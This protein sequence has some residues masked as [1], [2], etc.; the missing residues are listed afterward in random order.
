MPTAA[1]KAD[2]KQFRRRTL[3][4]AGVLLATAA[5][6]W[7]LYRLSNLLFMVFVSVFAGVAIEPAVHYLEKRGW[8]RGRATGVVF[9]AS[10]LLV[11]IF[12]IALVPLFVR[13]ID[14]L[15]DSVPT[16]VTRLA[17][18][19]EDTFGVQL[20]DPQVQ[21]EGQNL[22][23]LLTGAGG[24][25]VGGLLG[26]TAGVANFLI[27][28]TTVAIFTFYIVAELPKL[29]HTILSYMPPDRQREALH[30]WDIAVEKMGGYIYSRLILAVLSSFLATI[31]LMLLGVPF[32]VPLGIWVGVLS[33]FIPVI[34]TYLA[35]ILPAVVALSDPESGPATALWVV[36][37][38]ILYQQVENYLIAPRITKRTMEIHPAISIGAILAGGALMGGIGIILALPMA[39]IIQ[40]LI[41]EYATQRHEV[42]PE[43]PEPLPDD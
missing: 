29:Q 21:E 40:A 2:N 20:S 32:A 9:L 12:F 41:S 14:Q 3:V 35:A 7:L 24:T 16:Y 33:Q 1:E 39:G 6:L 22:A 18:F 8:K 38:F 15:I 4:V 37:Y 26:V 36:I 42:I 23:E 25:L 28:A 10:L 11:V 13:Q 43:V 5:T 27:F 17:Q 34:G 19:I 31:V 30:V